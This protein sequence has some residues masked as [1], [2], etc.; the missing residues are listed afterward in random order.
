MKTSISN[1]FFKNRQSDGSIIRKSNHKKTCNKL[2]IGPLS[3]FEPK[4]FNNP[5]EY[6]YMIYKIRSKDTENSDDFEFTLNINENY[7]A[8]MANVNYKRISIP[9]KVKENPYKL[10][11]FETT[12]VILG[13][14]YFGTV[15]L[16]Q[17]VDTNE[18]FAFKVIKK[19]KI[20][21]EKSLNQI[22]NEV[23]ILSNLDH[24]FIIQL[25]GQY[26]DDRKLY[27]Q[28][29]YVEGGDLH[30]LMKKEKVLS[31][32]SIKFIL[33]QIFLV[34]EYLHSHYILY[35]DI[36]PENILIDGNG[37]IKLADFGISK[38]LRYSDKQTTK[39]FCGT[40][41]FIPPEILK[42]EEYGMPVDMWSFGVLA[43]ELY[44]N[45]VSFNF[46][47]RLPLSIKTFQ[48]FTKKSFSMK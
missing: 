20:P 7:I 15:E 6:G 29:E 10:A 14:G 23:K 13:E 2:R 16:Y 37:Y 46:N 44:Y 30:K 24:P 9:G 25:F 48:I 35:R 11:N 19:S 3:E 34:L 39:T 41:E 5:C 32:K 28:T 4:N 33:A 1:H 26:Q 27:L 8:D 22:I 18:K 45:K 40:P 12:N 47:L 43:Y 17:K 36:K 38:Y 31:E 21:D 42:A